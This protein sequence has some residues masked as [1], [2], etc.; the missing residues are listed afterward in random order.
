MLTVLKYILVFVAV[1]TQIGCNNESG[2]TTGTPAISAPLNATAINRKNE[3]PTIRQNLGSNRHGLTPGVRLTPLMRAAYMGNAYKVQSLLSRG[4]NIDMK[5]RYGRTALQYAVLGGK[6]NTFTILFKAGAN[7]HLQN[8]FQASTVHLAAVWNRSEMVKLMVTSGRLDINTTSKFL[9]LTMLHSAASNCNLDLIQFLI[10]HG[11]DV[12][13]K[14]ADI[15]KNELLVSG[16]TPLKEAMA[17]NAGE[18][19][20]LLLQLGAD[21]ML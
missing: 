11:A 2:K 4:E 9:G 18:S 6:L 13:K 5:D 1:G 14:S 20:D 16:R 10:Q 17:V 7:I 19:I 21:P 8:S 15:K 3:C 12:N